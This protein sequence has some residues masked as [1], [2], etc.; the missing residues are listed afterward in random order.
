MIG[1]SGGLRG[2]SHDMQGTKRET[3]E[4]TEVPNIPSKVM[5]SIN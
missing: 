4:G 1:V 2:S 3:E 5:P